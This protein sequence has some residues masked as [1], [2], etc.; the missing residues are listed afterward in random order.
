MAADKK[1]SNPN[2]TLA[3]SLVTLYT[4]LESAVEKAIYPLADAGKATPSQPNPTATPAEHPEK[5][6]LRK[7]L[8][9]ADKTAILFGANLGSAPV[10]NH[11]TLAHN[12]TGGI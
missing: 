5:R 1:T 9:R 6:E 3:L 8:E 12:L 4:L 7:A 11:T 2:K 10:G